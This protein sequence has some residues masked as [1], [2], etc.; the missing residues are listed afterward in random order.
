MVCPW[1]RLIE[2]GCALARVAVL[3]AGFVVLV[4]HAAPARADAGDQGGGDQGNGGNAPTTPAVSDSLTLLHQLGLA[5]DYS[6][7]YDV[8]RSL[9]DWNQGIT[10][11]R[12]SDRW[13]VDNSWNYTIQNNSGQN[14]LKGRQGTAGAKVEYNAPGLGGWSFGSEGSLKRNFSGTAYDRSVNNET[15]GDLFLTW[16]AP[17][18]ALDRVFGVKPDALNWSITGTEGVTQGADIRQSKSLGAVARSDSTATSGGS[19]GYKTEFNYKPNPAFS[20]AATSELDNTREKSETW[21]YV[22]GP[23]SVVHE[24]PEAT[25]SNSDRHY[26]VNS[27]WQPSPNTRVALTGQFEKG[28]SQFYSSIVS[29]QDTKDG[30]DQ[31]LRL[32]TKLTPFWGIDID[33]NGNTEM[34]NIKYALETTGRGK[35]SRVSEGSIHFTTG[36]VFGFA[37]GTESTLEWR[38]EGTN[39]TFQDTTQ[40]AFWYRE[41]QLKETI[42]RPLT[43]QVTI[44]TTGEGTLDQSFYTDQSKDFDE[45]RWLLDGALAFK[46][47]DIIETHAAVQWQQHRTIDI[48]SSQSA[49]TNTQTH[50]QVEGEVDCQAAPDLK[51]TQKYTMSAD[52]ALYDLLPSTSNSN[53][54]VRTTEVRTEMDGTIGS[55]IHLQGDD[56]FRF[57]DSGFYVTQADGGPRLY[58][59][60]A[61]EYYQNL[62]MTIHYAFTSEFDVHS[63][64][65]YEIRDT[66]DLVKNT[67]VIAKRLEF[68]SG[69]ALDH[70]FSDAFSLHIT[71]DNTQ[72]SIENAYWQVSASLDRRF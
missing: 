17:G 25:D 56:Q 15:D 7:K 54:L 26:S 53:S 11:E 47:S 62:V 19:S 46:P 52:Y 9:T 66:K 27:T 13:T 67:S 60:T 71:A 22:A 38:F 5:P 29:A 39:N 30:Y 12:K 55:K 2:A 40:S 33:A 51:L 20:V 68:S 21:H 41:N 28:I 58:N 24:L 10:L 43:S 57:K 32:E 49:Q 65:R 42:R 31:N 69:M 72:S 36:P 61:T 18:E 64:S 23:D 70:K 8:N 1:G 45:L 50:Y 63:S 48:P 59:R 16:N 14:P 4:L 6:S 3:A 37:K 44:I 34:T 35:N